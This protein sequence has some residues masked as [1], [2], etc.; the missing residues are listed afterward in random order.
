MLPVQKT[1]HRI[2]TAKCGCCRSGSPCRRRRRCGRKGMCPLLLSVICLNMQGKKGGNTSRSPYPD[3]SAQQRLSPPPSSLSK[4]SGAQILREPTNCLSGLL[5]T[6]VG[7]Y[8]GCADAREV[9]EAAAQ[10]IV[11]L[12]LR[13]DRRHCDRSLNAICERDRRH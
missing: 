2:S 13:S 9:G 1:Q 6:Q 12:R 10:I 8:K 4:T 3:C 7:Q 5:R 11:L